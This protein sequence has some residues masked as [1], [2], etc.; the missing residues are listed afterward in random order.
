[1]TTRLG[2]DYETLSAGNPR[3]VYAS[4]TGFGQKGHLRNTK[5]Y[6]GVVAAKAGRMLDLFGQTK[7]DGPVYSA[8]QTATWAA[9]QAASRGILAALPL[10]HRVGRGRGVQPPLPRGLTPHEGA[11]FTR[12]STRGDPQRSPP[13]PTPPQ[14]Q[15]STLQYLPARTKDGQWIQHAN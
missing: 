2:I 3:L 4:I 15:L 10:G 9:S 12:Q 13:N 8:V 7:R 6:E 1:V 14:Q 5:G 11:L